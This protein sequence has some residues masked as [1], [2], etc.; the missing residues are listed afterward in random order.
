MRICIL[1]QPL[2][3]NYGGILQAYALQKVLRDYGHDVTT[4]RFLPKMPWIPTGFKFYALV[5]RR[6]VSKYF[7]GNRDII[8]CNPDKQT[9]YAYKD[10]DQFINKNIHNI[11]VKAPLSKKKLQAFDAYVVGSDQVWR[12][13]Y[14]PNL[15]NFY[16]DFLGNEIVKRVAYAASFGVDE[17]EA[18]EKTTGIIRPLAQKF[19][20][21]TVREISGINLCE[22]YLNVPA[23]YMPDPTL[24]LT[25]QDYLDLCTPNQ[26]AQQDRITV[27][28]LDKDE[29]KV[30]FVN[31]ISNELQLPVHYIGK[32]DWLSGVDSIESWLEG[33]AFSK[34]VITDSFHGTVFSI[35]FEK[36]FLSINNSMRGSSRFTSLLESVGL[37]DRLV[38]ENHLDD[39]EFNLPPIAYDSRE[40]SLEHIRQKGR[41][42]L[43]S[44]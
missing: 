39:Y 15:P 19:D 22:R 4:L 40:H 18:D 37:T 28:F 34:L 11:V 16:L 5:F 10:I 36:Q 9:R 43:Y 27:Y 42:F 20:A 41:S 8:Y 35:I 44:I 2:Q 24:L 33:I 31:R 7:K 30:A 6:F 23:T 1:T 13:A 26:F 21:I 32:A 14:S 38:D 17:W 25:A 29:K 12:P 3:A